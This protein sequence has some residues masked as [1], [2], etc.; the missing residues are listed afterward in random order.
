[1]TALR[2]YHRRVGEGGAE[3]GVRKGGE[4]MEVG[5][6]DDLVGRGVL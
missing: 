6:A 2:M 3:R 4:E 1:M 5:M